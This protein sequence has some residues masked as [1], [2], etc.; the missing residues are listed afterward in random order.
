MPVIRDELE[1]TKEQVGNTRD[2][3]G[4]D[5]DLR[6]PGRRLAAAIAFGP[7]RV[8]YVR[9]SCSARCR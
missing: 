4:R 6:A 2:R 7:R 9:C 3:L 1:L 8:Y 5:H